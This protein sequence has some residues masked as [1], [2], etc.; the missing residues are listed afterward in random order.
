MKD[1]FQVLIALSSLIISI[2]ALR[3]SR[4]VSL[5]KNLKEK[6]FELVCKLIKALSNETLLFNYQQSDGGGGTT[7]MYL[8]QFKAKNFKEKYNY[9]FTRKHFL[10]YQQSGQ[11]TFN[12][13]KGMWNPLMPKTIFTELQKLWTT[14][15]KDISESELHDLADYVIINCCHDGNLNHYDIPREEVFKNF[16]SFYN[17][18]NFLIETINEW[19]SKHE[20]DDLKF[21]EDIIIE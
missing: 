17:Q 5:K 16:V 18:V 2:V 7:L 14:Y 10:I 3:L 1:L 12:F 21:R 8:Y 4:K 15:N 9:L 13:L 11:L 20:A 6:Q 19:L